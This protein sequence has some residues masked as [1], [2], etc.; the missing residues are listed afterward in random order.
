MATR[1]HEIESYLESLETLYTPPERL[2]GILAGSRD[3]TVERAA[4][5][6]MPYKRT[7]ERARAAGCSLLVTHEPLEYNTGPTADPADERPVVAEQM[8]SKSELVADAGLTVLRC[9]DVWD[10][11]PGDGVTDQWGQRLGFTDDET[12]VREDYI[13]VYDISER[14]ARDV[15]QEIADNV[16]DLGQSAVELVGPDDTAVSRVAIGTGAITPVPRLLE[17]DPD[18]LVCTD[19]GFTHWRDGAMTIDAGVPAVVVNHAT[20]EV[21]SMATLVI[22]LD[23]AF[24]DLS[25]THFE[26]ECMFDLV[27][28]NSDSA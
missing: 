21:A 12:V 22:H 1:V 23:N 6:W 9:H 20:A 19:D 11:L 27:A 10:L 7:I 16:T 8:A 15:A 25:V 13:R 4:V 26:Q 3:D 2:D 28:G 24:P 14:V 17:H 18:L 5:A